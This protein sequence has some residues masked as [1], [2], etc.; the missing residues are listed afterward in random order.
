LSANTPLP[1]K[2]KK[3]GAHTDWKRNTIRMNPASLILKTAFDTDKA[4]KNPDNGGFFSAYQFA[5]TKL[6]FMI[7]PLLS[8]VNQCPTA[9]LGCLRQFTAC[10]S[11]S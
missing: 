10:P 6:C 5:Q 4:D 2:T 7:Y 9:L 8:Y 3:G 11:Y 1:V